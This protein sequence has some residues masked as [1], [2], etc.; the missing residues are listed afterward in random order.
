MNKEI[1]EEIKYDLSNAKEYLE[2]IKY[3][4]SNAKE[5]LE[6][7]KN[8]AKICPDSFD[9]ELSISLN[10]IK[11]SEFILNINS[12]IIDEVILKIQKLM[13]DSEK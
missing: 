5:Y 3:D 4:L 8:M 12:K 9:K 13:E 7:G 2:E 1:L 6:E 10:A 11:N